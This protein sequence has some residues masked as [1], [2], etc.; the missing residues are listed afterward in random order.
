MA[1]RLGSLSWNFDRTAANL[2]AVMIASLA[3]RY[4]SVGAEMDRMCYVRH[5]DKL[6]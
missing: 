6:H 3:V 4:M 1:S 5:L 2:T